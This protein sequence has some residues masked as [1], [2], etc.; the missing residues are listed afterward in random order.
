MLKMKRFMSLS[1]LDNYIL[2]YYYKNKK[3][4]IMW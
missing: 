4:K 1:K 2:F 3:E